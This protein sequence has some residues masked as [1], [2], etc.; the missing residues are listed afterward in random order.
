MTL[1]VAEKDLKVVQRK[2]RQEK[3]L[4]WT[5]EL[6]TPLGRE[7][8]RARRLGCTMT[9]QEKVVSGCARGG[10]V[11]ILGKIIHHNGC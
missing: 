2:A 10:S 8:P 11:W 4:S 5:A 9:G 1:E 3:L 6:K 7:S